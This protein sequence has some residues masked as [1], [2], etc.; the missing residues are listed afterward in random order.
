MRVA[1]F[2]AGYAGLTLARR[3]SDSLDDAELVVV[4][5]RDSHLV[6]H[7]L[8]RLVRRP[9]LEDHLLLPL[10]ELL[11]DVTVHENRVTDVDP[12]G[13]VA[14]FADG[15]DLTYDVGAVCLGGQPAYYEL[16]GI[17]AHATP[18]K[19][20]EHAAAIRRDFLEGPEDG[21]VVVG[22]AGLSGIQVAGELAALAR[23]EGRS[24]I[25]TL[26]EREQSV[27]P[28]FSGAFQRA[29]QD[30][31]LDR[32]IEVRTGAR[33]SGATDTAVTL[34]EKRELPYDQFVWTGGIQGPAAFGGE[35]PSV[36]STLSLTERTFVLGDSAR[37]VDGNGQL[38]PATA[39][40][41]IRGAEV[42]ARNIERLLE[43]DPD[44]VF[45]PRFEQFVFDPRAWVVSVGDQVVAQVGPKVLTGHPAKVLK[46]TVGARYMTSVGAVADAVDVVY[47]E[48]GLTE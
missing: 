41:A 12:D 4:D 21:R 9:S 2:G 44:S 5:E 18:L 25:I 29:I 16:P 35:R 30:A 31:L 8:H 32:D 3:L 34:T 10:S 20:V 6:Q 38:V 17:E 45:E 36:R 15:N 37:V 11:G 24:P 23:E 13:G 26:L 46:T 22:G 33:I 42:V 40:A 28:G 48:L 1:I 7:E 43:H 39:Q 19:Q 47:E 27:A 14:T